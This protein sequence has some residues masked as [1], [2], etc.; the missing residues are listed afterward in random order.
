MLDDGSKY[1]GKSTTVSRMGGVRHRGKI[2][3]QT[4]DRDP[5]KRVLR[6]LMYVC[7]RRFRFVTNVVAIGFNGIMEEVFRVLF[8]FGERCTMGL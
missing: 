5:S 6:V 2:A 4:C 7:Q 1:V 3:C 8:V